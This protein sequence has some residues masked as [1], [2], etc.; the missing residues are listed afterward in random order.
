M[1][2]SRL[3][4]V[5]F[6]IQIC[7]LSI[8]GI[9]ERYKFE[10]R[11]IMDKEALKAMGLSDEQIT[12]VIEQHDNDIKGAYI[13]KTRM[14]ELN[15][16]NKA[17]KEQLTGRDKDIVDLKKSTGD[18]AELSKQFADLQG[19]YKTD[20]EA[21][22]GKLKQNALN[23]ALDLGITKAKG[24]DSIAIKAHIDPSKLTL[25]DDGSVDGLDATLEDLKKNNSYLFEQVETRQVGNGFNGSKVD[26]T[27]ELTTAADTFTKA[28][29]G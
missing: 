13:P 20:T 5:I 29:N 2:I 25:K 18:N 4:A 28:L 6:Y 15:E 21:L 19:K 3:L 22:T 12:K 17:L 26:M 1:P 23:A 24:K 11:I 10:W 8:T 27:P 7:L 14:D 9:K 16:T